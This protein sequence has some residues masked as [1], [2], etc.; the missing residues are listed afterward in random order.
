MVS[1]SR[2][3]QLPCPA[4][5]F[6]T[7]DENCYGS[8][9]ICP[10]CAWEDDAVQLANPACGGGAN[11]SSL[12]DVQISILANLPLNITVLD[13]VE[14]SKIWR[15]LNSAEQETAEKQKQEKVWLNKAIYDPTAVYWNTTKPIYVIDGNDFT[16]LEGFFDAISSSLIPDTEWGRN[17]DAL[18]DILR[19]GFGTADSGFVIRWLN[20]HKSREFLG[21]TE[22]IRQLNIQLQSCHP[23]SVSYI[24]EKITA[25][26]SGQGSTVYDWLL[27]IIRAHCAGGKESQDGVE[28]L[29]E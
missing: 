20:S 28:L 24:G 6:H 1:L 7:I 21:Y 9:N 14:R 29:L 4:C 22:T 16:T 2:E 25:A 8:Y 27:E 19:G 13:G 12:V 11:A 3:K 15:P 10:I 18:N 23:S 26:E 17:L 5:G